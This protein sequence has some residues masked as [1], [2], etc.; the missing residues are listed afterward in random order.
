LPI[1]ALTV[2]R[3][4][5]RVCIDIQPFAAGMVVEGLGTRLGT[6]VEVRS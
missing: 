5:R 2:W 4:E 1:V 6:L 3:E